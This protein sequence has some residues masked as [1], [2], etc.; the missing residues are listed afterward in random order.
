MSSITVCNSPTGTVN[1]VTVS[2]TPVPLSVLQ[3]NTTF[4]VSTAGSATVLNLPPVAGASGVR[5]KVINQGGTANSVTITAATAVLNGFIVGSGTVVQCTN[6]TNLVFVA[7][8]ALKGD[9]VIIESDGTNWYIDA[10]GQTAG[11]FTVS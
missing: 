11:C 8:T 9:F 5:Y 1:T 4:Y 6:K 10:R 3:S 7:A 2:T